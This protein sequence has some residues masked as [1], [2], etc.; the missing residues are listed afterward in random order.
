MKDIISHSW[1]GCGKKER[2][3]DCML[4]H[5]EMKEKYRELVRKF[6]AYRD[7]KNCERMYEAIRGME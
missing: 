7:R 4:N 2:M 3:D 1:T 5:G 6:F